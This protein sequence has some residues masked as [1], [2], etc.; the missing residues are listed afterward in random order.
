MCDDAIMF[1]DWSC[2]MYNGRLRSLRH[3]FKRYVVI[4][5]V[6]GNVILTRF[7]CSLVGLPGYVTGTHFPIKI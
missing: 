6:V 7:S 5:A 2:V 4:F 3:Y 1:L